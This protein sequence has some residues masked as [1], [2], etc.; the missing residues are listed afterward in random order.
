MTKKDIKIIEDA[1]RFGDS[2][3]VSDT[4]ELKNGMQFFADFNGVNTFR[5]RIFTE[6]GIENIEFQSLK[7]FLKFLGASDE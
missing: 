5:I 2:G 1:L 3:D 7:T 4:Y 6:H